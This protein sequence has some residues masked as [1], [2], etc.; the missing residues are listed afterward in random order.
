MVI[1][2]K[3]AILHALNGELEEA[4]TL[5]E[6]NSP[7]TNAELHARL[8]HELAEAVLF[9]Y[10]AV[11][12]NHGGGRG[13]ENAE[14]LATNRNEKLW[15]FQQQFALQSDP[16]RGAIRQ[17]EILELL[18]FCAEFLLHDSTRHEDW[19]TLA[20]DVTQ[21]NLVTANFLRQYP[22]SI[23]F[24]RRFYEVLI[25]SAALLHEKQERPGDKRTQINNIVGLLDRMRPSEGTDDARSTRVFFFLPD[26]N[27]PE[28]GFVLFLPRD[29][30]EGALYPLPL[31]R[32]MVK[33]DENQKFPP[34][35]AELLEQIAA[36]KAAG[37]SIRVSWSDAAA[38]ANVESALTDA[39]YP[40]ND[41]LPLR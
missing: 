12:D 14:G 16:A 10:D 30:R 34:L 2:W 22:G 11:S 41:V 21:I 24:M 8:V 4:H 1:R 32:L 40:F 5:L 28:E 18:L 27:K 15:A 29:G 38:W 25:R 19:E 26:T 36:E 9:Y 33:Q 23:P 37:R 20:Q 17:P 6:R 39:E 7:P 31:T 13:T 3:Q 35:D